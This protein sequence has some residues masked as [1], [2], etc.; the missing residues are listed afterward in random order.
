MA[1]YLKIQFKTK[2]KKDSGGYLMKRANTK[3]RDN[4]YRR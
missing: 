3:E 1:V 4:R 2:N